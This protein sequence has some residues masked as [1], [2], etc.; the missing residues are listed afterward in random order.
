LVCQI[1]QDGKIDIILSK[2]LSVL[3]ETERFEPVRNLLH[4]GP[5]S[6]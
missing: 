3:R 5:A 6:G 1:R 2:A 4:R